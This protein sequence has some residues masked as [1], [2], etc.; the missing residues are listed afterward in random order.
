VQAVVVL[1]VIWTLI[2]VIYFVVPHDP[3]RLLL[4][5][6]APE[7]AVQKLRVTLGL[8]RPVW[9]QYVAYFSRIFHGNLGQSFLR[10]VG[11]PGAP[12][13]GLIAADIPVDVELAL[14]AAALWLLVGVGIGILSVWR[15]GS[16]R[17]RGA[18]I[19]IFSIVST[20]AFVLGGLALFIS[21]DV[22][23]SH[24]IHLF[25]FP[26]TWVPL[27]VDPLAWADHLVLPWIT[28]ALVNSAVY[29]RLSRSSLS[30][31][32][33]EDYI[34]TARAKGVAERR[35]LFRHALRAALTPL[36]TQFG[37]DLGAVLA[38]AV[39]VEVVFGLPGLGHQLISAVQT[40]D[41]PTVQGIAL[42]ISAVVVAA[43]LLVDLLYGV[44]DP[45]VRLGAARG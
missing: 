26:G 45:R 24:G 43:N 37:I 33:A 27:H 2:F 21:D 11:T 35:V 7:E 40:E 17:A 19:F 20:P 34:R 23:S 6:R 14:P 38:G 3:A 36:M 5:F 41:L 16:L 9:D 18:T 4:G 1:W 22:L 39:V 25:P 8:E 31:V 15:R 10:S 42:F 32:L 28:L 29:A 13:T 44:V 30:E 12:V